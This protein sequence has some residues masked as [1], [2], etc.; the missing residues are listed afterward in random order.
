MSSCLLLFSVA[1]SVD[2]SSSSLSLLSVRLRSSFSN[3]KVRQRQS[4]TYRFKAAIFFLL[5]VIIGGSC[6]TH[7]SSSLLLVTASC[8]VYCVIKGERGC[9]VRQEGF[10]HSNRLG[11]F[12]GWCGRSRQSVLSCN[13]LIDGSHRK[14]VTCREKKK[15]NQSGSSSSLLLIF[16]S[17]EICPT[18]I[19]RLILGFFICQTNSL[20]PF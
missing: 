17:L 14:P 12:W 13:Q 7:T 1:P 10:L 8:C 15:Y 18:F 20:K 6:H 11:Q 5:P 3:S 2:L 19:H 16:L 4:C 9:E